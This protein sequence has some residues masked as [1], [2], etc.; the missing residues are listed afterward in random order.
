M[1]IY[2]TYDTIGTREDL[3]NSIWD[4]SPS[5]TPFMSSIAKV[6]A[7]NTYHEWQTD[8]LRAPAKNAKVEGADAGNGSHSPT[9]RLGNYTQIHDE[10]AKVSGTNQKTDKAGRANE[11]DYQ[12]V[13][14]SM[15]IKT[16]VEFSLLTNG[17]RVAG[18]NAT[19]R[20]LAGVESYVKSNVDAG[21]GAVEATGN[22]TDARTPGTAR[23]FADAQL[24]SVMEK[25]FIAG[26]K[27]S[28]MFLSVPLMSKFAGFGSNLTKNVDAD[29]KSV[30][31][32]V[33]VYVSQF[34]SVVAEP[35]RIINATTALVADTSL[36]KLAVLREFKENELAK[37]GDFDKVQII[38]EV[39]LAALNE[40]GS[41]AVYDVN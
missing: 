13:K 40:K 34:G 28:K 12:I 21:A 15:E 39:S 31:K 33:S 27:P 22:G 36:F 10:V 38:T 41:G 37:T 4:V 23:A 6:Q 26:G 7:T 35:S 17:A 19:A 24:D 25:C 2:N 18:D 5:E 3:Q 29:K 11:M 8:E 1:A 30:E 32:A 20:E 16:D 9:V 14:K